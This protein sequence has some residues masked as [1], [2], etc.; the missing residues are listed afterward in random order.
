MQRFRRKKIRNYLFYALGETF[1]IVLGIMIAVQINNSNETKKKNAQRQTYTNNLISELE[2]DI[3]HL[4]KLAGQNTQKR[5]SILKYID[6]YNSENPDPGILHL[7]LDSI[8]TNK[9]AFYSGAYSI[10][11]L[12]TTG[13]LS[14]FS[15][16]EK[17]AILTLKN[18]HDRYL[19]YEAQNIQ[20]V[21]LYEQEI[22]KNFD[23]LYL[24]G[25]SKKEHPDTK[26]WKKDLNSNQFRI[27]HNSLAENLKLFEFQNHMYKEIRK[28]TSELLSI[29]EKI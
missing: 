22:K 7:K 29:L 17:T 8:G 10:E 6:Y 18:V 25:L 16:K 11:D 1:L 5:N 19:Y 20:D 23:L 27:L 3:I 13:N 14:L 4:K 12:V 24:N 28:A 21:A 9:Q 2:Y 26:H 15:E